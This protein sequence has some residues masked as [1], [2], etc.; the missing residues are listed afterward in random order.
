MRRFLFDQMKVGDYFSPVEWET[1]VSERE[2]QQSHSP[3]EGEWLLPSKGGPISKHVKVGK[4]HKYSHGSPSGSETRMTV[5]SR[6][7]SNILDWTSS[8]QNFL[9][10]LLNVF[11]R[12]RSGSSTR[13]CVHRISFQYFRWIFW[14][15]YR[16]FLWQHFLITYWR[17]SYG[18][19]KRWCSV[20]GQK[21]IK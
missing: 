18:N 13:G 4:E 8:S 11:W 5:L 14:E 2:I 21:D 6:D 16:S 10:Y 12:S 15:R 17:N 7:S 20:N 9:H 19:K 1:R 3:V